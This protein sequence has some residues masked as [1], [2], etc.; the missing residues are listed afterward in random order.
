MEPDELVAARYRLVARVGRGAMGT[1]WRAR[2][3]R[4]DRVVAVKELLPD[5]SSADE[6]TA[7]A[8][9]EGRIASRLRHPNAIAVHDVVTHDGRPCLIMEYLPSERLGARGALPP[10]EVARIGAQVAGA[11]AAA[12][13]AGIVHRDVKPENVLIGEDGTAKITDFGISRAAGIGTV[14]AT[15][16]LAGTPAYLAP[17]VAGGADADLRSDVFSLGA[18]LYSAVEGTPPF[19]LDD[20]PIALLHR[21]A[22]GEV[23]PPLLA[24]PL[25]GTLS[26]LLRR[27]P[28]E[29]PTMRAAHEALAA[30]A[31]GRPGPEPA[32]RTPTLMLPAPRRVSRRA[33]VLGASAAGLVAAGIVLGSLLNDPT[34]V[35]APSPTTAH[36]TTTTPAAPTCAATYSITNSWAAG[37]QA[38]VTVRNDT[39]ETLTGW[40][41]TWTLP[42]GHEINNL[43]GGVVERDGRA[44]TVTNADW[45]VT[46]SPGGTTSFGL[47]VD[48]PENDHRAPDPRCASR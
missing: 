12:H 30:V 41:V 5:D 45:N 3:E 10:A 19:G 25:T 38:E 16:I 7:R 35:G 4:L 42:D 29:R 26:W 15:G 24:G 17:E 18:T 31:A 21:V 27:D 37:Y 8:L 33:V 40:V 34:S 32:P 11:L 43:W 22:A 44:V 20:N 2:D 13:A 48:T 39:A 1:V 14:S 23:R 46:V 28:A 9:R 6:A 36:G 47:I